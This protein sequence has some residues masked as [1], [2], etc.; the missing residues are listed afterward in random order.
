[1]LFKAAWEEVVESVDGVDDVDAEE[2]DAFWRRDMLG[3]RRSE[4]GTGATI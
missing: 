4:R 3:R 2:G 1:M